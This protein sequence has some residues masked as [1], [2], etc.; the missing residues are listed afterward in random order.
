MKAIT[1]ILVGVVLV[2]L[3]STTQVSAYFEG[4]TQHIY[5][6]E[7]DPSTWDCITSINDGAWGKLQVIENRRYENGMFVFNGHNLV[8]GDHWVLVNWEESWPKAKYIADGIVDVEGNLHLIGDLPVLDYNT[9]T[10]GEYATIIGAKIW[11]IH[12]HD[13]NFDTQCVKSWSPVGWLFETELV[14]ELGV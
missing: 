11:L 5:M 14:M 1:K 2:V 6:F 12:A 8:E 7:K 13:Y 3:L 4:N 10:S 9:Y